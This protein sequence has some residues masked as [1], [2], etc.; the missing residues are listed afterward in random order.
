M[1]AAIKNY[2]KK[3]AVTLTEL[4]ITVVIVAVIA[5][6]AVPLYNKAM[7]KQRKKEAFAVLELMA[8]AEN[9]YYS[10][11]N[12]YYPTSGFENNLRIINAVFGLRIPDLGNWGYR[13]DSQEGGQGVRVRALRTG[14]A[15]LFILLSGGAESD[16]NF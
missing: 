15:D 4:A 9:R 5:S 13:L 6:L 3:S 10:R 14:Q 2:I 11:N 7:E 12:I 1:G 8:A 16:R